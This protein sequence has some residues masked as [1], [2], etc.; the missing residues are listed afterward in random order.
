MKMWNLE[1]SDVLIVTREKCL[2][3]PGSMS[4][5]KEMKLEYYGRLVYFPEAEAI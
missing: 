5:A 4:S 1:V 2:E 3:E